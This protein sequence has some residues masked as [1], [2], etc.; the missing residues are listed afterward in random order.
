MTCYCQWNYVTIPA[1]DDQ[2]EHMAWNRVSWCTAC[3]KTAKA[4][5][6]EW[7]TNSPPIKYAERDLGAPERKRKA[8]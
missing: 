3:M 8:K 4:E 6:R 2:P 5:A 1:K 7:H